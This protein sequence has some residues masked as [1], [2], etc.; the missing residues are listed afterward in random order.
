MI[1]VT[2]KA[3]ADASSVSGCKKNDELGRIRTGD[4][5]RVKTDDFGFSEAF[6]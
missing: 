6:S 2:G 4:L 3:P 5:R 1:L